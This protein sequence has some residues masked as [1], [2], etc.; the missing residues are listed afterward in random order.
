MEKIQLQSKTKAL[1]GAI[2][3]YWFENESIG[4]KNTLF[5]RLTIPL[6]AFDS[7]LDYEEQPVDTKIVLD[8]YELELSNESHLD[9]LNLKHELYPDA[10]GSVY[11]GCAHN[12]CDVKELKISQNSNGCFTAVGELS[13]EFENEGV[14]ENELFH[15]RTDLDFVKA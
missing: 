15:F 8:W 3:A 14:A 7:G 10:E 1:K 11:I 4:L 2:E 12:W 9:G 13:I 6:I 5:H